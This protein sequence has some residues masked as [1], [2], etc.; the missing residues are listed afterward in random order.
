MGGLVAGTRA[1]AVQQQWLPASQEPWS[2]AQEQSLPPLETYSLTPDDAA[3][4]RLAQTALTLLY[5]RCTAAVALGSPSE[6]D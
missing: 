1:W 6:D 4:R 2:E 3:V 5:S